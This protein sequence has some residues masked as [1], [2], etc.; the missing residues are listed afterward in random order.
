MIKISIIT[1]CYNAEST[2][3]QTIESVLAQTYPYVEYI[4]IDG[5]STD[6]TLIYIQN[7]KKKILDK[8]YEFI[9]LSEKDSGIYDAMNK[10]ILLSTGSWI[11][12]RNSG[13]YFFDH[14]ILEK[15]FMSKINK[16]TKIIH[17]DIRMYDNYGYCDKK[18]PILKQ[19]YKECMPVWHPSTFV[20]TELHKK[21]LFDISFH[22]SGDYD[23]FYKCCESNLSFQY[24]PLI[25]ALVNV[26]EGASINNYTLGLKEN[27][28]LQKKNKISL[29]YITL[30]ISN[31]I[32]LIRSF[33]KRLLPSNYTNKIK[34]KSRLKEGWNINPYN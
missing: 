34:I 16:E 27:F 25:V 9:Y 22:L 10:G 26:E 32:I 13:D 4:I 19:S 29:N 14:E 1:V 17:G 8:G 6:N 5:N 3:C 33:L 31:I 12:F 2:I 21:L 18:P 7:F 11:H 15:I 24:F 28:R 30:N 23:F 20:K